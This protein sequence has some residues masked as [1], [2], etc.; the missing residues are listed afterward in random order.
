M[1]KQKFGLT[2]SKMRVLTFLWRGYSTVELA[3]LW[4][5]HEGTLRTHLTRIYS[6]MGVRS[7]LGA[8]VKLAGLLAHP[9]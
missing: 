9:G 3:E 2:G 4:D 8:V 6:K 1:A 5:K 7:A